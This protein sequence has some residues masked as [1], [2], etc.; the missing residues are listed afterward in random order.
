MYAHHFLLLI[1]TGRVDSYAG[2]P[3]VAHIQLLPSYTQFIICKGDKVMRYLVFVILLCIHQFAY[4]A[5]S[6]SC[7]RYDASVNRCNYDANSAVTFAL[8]RV[9]V[10]DSTYFSDYTEG[11]YGGNCTNFASQ[12]ILAG[13]TGKTTSREIWK[14]RGSYA[15]DKGRCNYCWYFLAKQPAGERGGAFLLANELYKY[16]KGNKPHYRGL[17]FDFI[18]KDSSNSYLDV[19]RIKPGDIIFGDF[20]GDGKVEHTMI[21]TGKKSNSKDY[22]GILVSY[23]NAEGW[24]IRKN[25]SLKEINKRETV[26]LVYRPT[27]YSDHGQ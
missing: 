14:L 25:S 17:H 7:K 19:T 22:S 1:S 15:T 3:F 23:Q 26:W 13:L 8:A 12:V 4:A 2:M 27:F 5:N 18:T 10:P 6:A 21:V 20:H 11:V 9:S 24:P 16:A